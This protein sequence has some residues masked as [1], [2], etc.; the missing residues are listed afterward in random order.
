[1]EAI[2]LYTQL[3]QH[4]KE[5]MKCKERCVRAFNTSER[6][7][8]RFSCFDELN[9]MI[10]EGFVPRPGFEDWRKK[11]TKGFRPLCVRLLNKIHSIAEERLNITELK[12]AHL[13]D[14]VINNAF[15]TFEDRSR[16]DLSWGGGNA[17]QL[18]LRR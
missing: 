13:A 6:H 3:D 1:M 9:A 17:V 16:W 5:I 14:K 10:G 2:Q 8:E 15:P 4:R 11:G 7:S 18:I 12:N